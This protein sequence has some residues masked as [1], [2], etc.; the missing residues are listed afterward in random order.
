MSFDDN[1]PEIMKG[2]VDGKSDTNRSTTDNNYVIRHLPTRTKKT[3][4]ECSALDLSLAS[5]TGSNFSQTSGPETGLLSGGRIL[6]P[7]FVVSFVPGLVLFS[8]RVDHHDGCRRRGE[9]RHF[10]TVHDIRLA[11]SNVRASC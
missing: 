3:P 8:R 4:R 11:C 7:W 9:H 6:P 2:K 10:R 1:R 5:K